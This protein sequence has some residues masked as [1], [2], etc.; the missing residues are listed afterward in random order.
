MGRAALPL[1]SSL[2]SS[3]LRSPRVVAV[4]VVA[5]TAAVVVVVAVSWHARACPYACMH[6]PSCFLTCRRR[7]IRSSRGQPSLNPAAAIAGNPRLAAR[8]VPPSPMSSPRWT[9]TRSHYVSRKHPRN[10]DK[11]ERERARERAR[12][13][14]QRCLERPIDTI[15]FESQEHGGIFASVSQGGGRTRARAR[16][17]TQKGMCCFLN[18]DLAGK[19]MTW[20]GCDWIRPMAYTHRTAPPRSVAAVRCAGGKE[21]THRR[22]SA[23]QALPTSWTLAGAR[24]PCRWS[25]CG[26]AARRCSSWPFRTRCLSLRCG[27]S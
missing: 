2:L 7:T 25:T 19:G 9:Q 16:A 18:S 27:A 5:A 1:A 12:R 22:I 26:P 8:L 23:W 10:R 6:P 17:Q 13:D 24:G 11:G 14:D 4:A 3:S 20:G 21:H 15:R